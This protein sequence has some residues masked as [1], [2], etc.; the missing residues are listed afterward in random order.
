MGLDSVW[1]CAM[2]N[3]TVWIKFQ[4]LVVWGSL[5]DY[6]NRSTNKSFYELELNLL[7]VTEEKDDNRWI[8]VLETMEA[9]A[10]QLTA[11]TKMLEVRC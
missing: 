6:I 4:I 3:G 1:I 5:V 7:H 8:Y 10:L 11:V 2:A 9:I